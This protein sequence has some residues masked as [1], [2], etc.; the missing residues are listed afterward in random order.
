MFTEDTVSMEHH[1]RIANSTDSAGW[2][3]VICGSMFSGKTE[4]LI[5][6]LKRAKFANLRVEIF[7]PQIDVRYSEDEVVSHDANA[8]RSTPVESPGNI[9]LM[10]SD[11]DVVG[12]DE[13]QFFDQSIVDVCRQL[14]DAGGE[15]DCC[16][17]RH[18]LRRQAFR[19]D[20]CAYGY[21]G[22]CDQSACD[23][24]QVRPSGP[25]FASPHG[26]RKT[27]DAGRKGYLRTRMQAL[28]QQG[29][30]ADA[31]KKRPRSFGFRKKTFTFAAKKNDSVNDGY[32]QHTSS[33][34]YLA[35]DRVG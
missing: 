2:I 16:R 12:I 24:R 3:E 29:Q 13:A 26:G 19:A 27:R 4:E 23:L 32:I 11:V 6:R 25:V 14:A 28:F 22:V 30:K 9:L 17:S 5:R 33:S 34:P 31:L 8:I 21:G 35:G 15:G 20:A 1:G 7:K 18:G 10:A